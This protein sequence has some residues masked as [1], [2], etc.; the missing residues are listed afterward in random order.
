MLFVMYITV[1]HQRV[2][3][4][5]QTSEFPQQLVQV[6]E[7][8]LAME[9]RGR[10]HELD[11]LAARVH[12]LERRLASL[13]TAAADAV[14]AA[15][16]PQV[17]SDRGAPR[18]SRRVATRTAAAAAAVA[19]VVAVQSCES[20]EWTPQAATAVPIWPPPAE[21]GGAACKPTPTSPIARVDRYLLDEGLTLLW[22]W[23]AGGCGGLDDESISGPSKN[24]AGLSNLVL[25]ERSRLTHFGLRGGVH[26]DIGAHIGDTSAGMATLADN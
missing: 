4:A 11:T 1:S 17:L 15:A 10:D 18:P 6:E 21:V 20:M 22:P 26:L 3:T 14:V 25:G 8:V 12:V 13:P 24:G 2:G 7:R 5:G 19:K 23:K 16:A 9:Q